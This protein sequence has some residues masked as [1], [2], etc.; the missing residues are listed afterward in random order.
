M[1]HKSKGLPCTMDLPLW[2]AQQTWTSISD[3]VHAA[4]WIMWMACIIIFGS[5]IA[6]KATPLTT[7]PIPFAMNLGALQ[8]DPG[9][10]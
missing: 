1:Q 3:K 6:Y 8:I 5:A 2:Y 7:M 9:C 10:M 4:L